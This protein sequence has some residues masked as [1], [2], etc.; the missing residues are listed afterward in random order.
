VYH[1]DGHLLLELGVCPLGKEN[2]AHTADTQGAQYAILSDAIT[3]HYS[4]HAPRRG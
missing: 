1:F 3:Y 2:F 4:K